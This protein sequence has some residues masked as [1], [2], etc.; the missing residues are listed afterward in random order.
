MKPRVL[1]DRA[2]RILDR[3]AFAIEREAMLPGCDGLHLVSLVGTFHKLA[4]D[5]ER[6]LEFYLEFADVKSIAFWL[7][8]LRRIQRTHTL[9]RRSAGMR[10]RR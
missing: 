1:R 6:N 4:G 5:F 7:R 9:C 8:Q 3:L 10:L 2:E